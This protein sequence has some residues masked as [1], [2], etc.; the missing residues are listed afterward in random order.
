MDTS[1]LSAVCRVH[2]SLLR[3]NS[4]YLCY[5]VSWSC[6]T[7]VFIFPIFCLNCIKDD[8]FYFY[9]FDIKFKSLFPFALPSEAFWGWMPGTARDP[10]CKWLSVA[11]LWTHCRGFL[12]TWAV[13]YATCDTARSCD[14]ALLLEVVCMFDARMCM[15]LMVGVCRATLPECWCVTLQHWLAYPVNLFPSSPLL[16]PSSH[17]FLSLPSELLVFALYHAPFCFLLSSIR[18]E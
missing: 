6:P 8:F 2:T 13:D 18:S 7:S 14:K 10:S 5:N 1:V 12:S 17:I 4:V 11:I 16:L 9:W 3:S 15:C